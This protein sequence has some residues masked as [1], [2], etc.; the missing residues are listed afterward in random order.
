M[1]LHLALQDHADDECDLDAV[2]AAQDG[3][4]EAWRVFVN[5]VAVASPDGTWTAQAA[6]AD[7][8]T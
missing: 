1:D 7:R 2:Q 3:V 8:S 6:F 4:T 5:A